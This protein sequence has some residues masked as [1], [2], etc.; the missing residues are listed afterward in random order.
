[1]WYFRSLL[2]GIPEPDAH[3]RPEQQNCANHTHVPTCSHSFC[4]RLSAYMS[5]Q[6]T[7]H[8]SQMC[9]SQAPL[10]VSDMKSTYIKLSRARKL[11]K[12]QAHV[13]ALPKFGKS[14]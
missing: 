9:Y 14:R 12:H 3:F 7:E 10:H 5:V 2:G 6:N 1:M 13:Q 4:R 8:R 11:R